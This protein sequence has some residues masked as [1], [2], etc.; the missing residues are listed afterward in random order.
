MQDFV[1]LISNVGFPIFACIMIYKAMEKEREDHKEESEKWV[2]A[3][4][5]NTNV[6]KT[7]ISR[8]EEN[9]GRN[10]LER[11]SHL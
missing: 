11:E 1:S 8:M 7:F 10:E 4:N 9:H 3:L 2:Q 5:N 6:M